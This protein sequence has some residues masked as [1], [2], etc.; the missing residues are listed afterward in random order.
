MADTVLYEARR[1]GRHADAQPARAPEHDRPRADRRAR[2]GARSR[3]Q[4]D[5]EVRV[6]RLRGAGR[7]FC[8]G[9]DIDWGAEM[10]EA[11][12][13]GGPVGPDPRL[14][15]DVALRQLLHAPVALAEAG[16]RPGARLLRRRRHRLR[17]LLGPDRLLGGLPHRLP[18]GARVGI[19]DDGDVDLPARA[20]ALEAPAADGRP[21]RRAHGGRVGPRV[22]GGAGGR[23]R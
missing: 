22:G 6:I 15:D 12:R 11:G 19:A 9:Y 4:A 14:P 5:P 20:R 17:A 18:A 13:A 1:R 21:A 7:T 2:R 3:A 10:M 23:A 16:D 8:A